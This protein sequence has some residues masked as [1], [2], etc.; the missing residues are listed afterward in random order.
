MSEEGKKLEL[1]IHDNV[2]TRENVGTAPTIEQLGTIEKQIILVLFDTKKMLASAV[3]LYTK[4]RCFHLVISLE[5]S[6][7]NIDEYLAEYERQKEASK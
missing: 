1:N 3:D 7:K 5:A 2:K 4:L 6:I